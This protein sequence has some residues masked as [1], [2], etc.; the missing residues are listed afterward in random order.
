VALF[1]VLAIVVLGGLGYWAW[2]LLARSHHA[3]LAA[4]PTLWC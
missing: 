3:S 2:L 1:V 4:V